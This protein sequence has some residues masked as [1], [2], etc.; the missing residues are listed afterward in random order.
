MFSRRAKLRTVAAL[1]LAVGI[2]ACSDSGSP[3][4][5]KTLV[6][7]AVVPGFMSLTVEGIRSDDRAVLFKIAGLASSAGVQLRQT[8]LTMHARPGGETLTVALFGEAVQGELATIAIPNIAAPPP[9]VVSLVEVANKAGALRPDSALAT[10]KLSI[11][12]R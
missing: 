10:Y 5:P 8:G 12:P 6:P 2:A 3:T 11:R 7:V 4:E 9:Y 1:G